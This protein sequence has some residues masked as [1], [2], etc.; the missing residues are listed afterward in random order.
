M[1]FEG[2]LY[3]SSHESHF[4]S[5]RSNRCIYCVSGSECM[6]SSFECLEIYESTQKISERMCE[7]T[8]GRYGCV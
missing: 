3:L 7:L 2:L 5:R 6:F 4:V 8:R 1:R